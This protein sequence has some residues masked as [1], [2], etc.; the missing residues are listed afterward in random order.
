MKQNETN[1]CSA[2]IKTQAHDQL[3]R[4]MSFAIRG[5]DSVFLSLHFQI[6][7]IEPLLLRRIGRGL[8]VIVCVPSARKSL[9]E[10]Y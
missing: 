1:M 10:P 3:L 7:K 8:N 5:C 6:S 9:V 4:F 2:V